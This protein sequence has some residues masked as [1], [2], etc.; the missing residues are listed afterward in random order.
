MLNN[1]VITSSQNQYVSL[2]RSLDNRKNREK[3]RLFRIDGVKLMC[4]ALKKG[5]NIRFALLSESFYTIVLKKAERLYG[6]CEKDIGFKTV[7]VADRIFEQLSEEK[8]PE[9]IICV[10]EYLGDM[11]KDVSAEDAIPADRSSKI[12][13]LESLRDPQN[14]GAI[15][16]VAAAFGVDRIIMSNDCA[17]IYSSKTLRAAMGAAFTVHIDRTYDLPLTVRKLIESGR[18]VFA[19]ALNRDSKKLGEF[20]IMSG[21]CVVIG[22]EGHGLSGDTLEA[23]GESVFIPMSEGV[24]SLNAATAAA[25]LVWEFFGSGK[26]SI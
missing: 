13:L 9:G 18:R 12:L 10:A 3:Q 22:N 26:D 16:R 8:S 7:I 4:E 20:E 11:H 24:E 6:V 5:V 14:V 21:D 2:T 15:I 23:C 19:A 25:V 1:K 17:D